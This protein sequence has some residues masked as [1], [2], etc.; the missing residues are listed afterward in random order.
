MKQYSWSPK[1]K[2]KIR[3]DFIAWIKSINNGFSSRIKYKPFEQYC[4][5]ADDWMKDTLFENDMR[6]HQFDIMKRE[7]D[8][9]DSNSYYYFARYVHIKDGDAP[10]GEWSPDNRTTFDVQKVFAFLNDTGLS[11]MFGKARQIG[12]TSEL[13]PIACKEAMCNEGYFVKFVCENDDKTEEIFSDKLKYS[14]YKLP[15][16]MKPSVSNDSAGLLQFATKVAKGKVEGMMSKVA[17]VGPTRTAIN[18]GSPNKTLVDE[19]GEIGILREMMDEARPTLYMYNSLTEEWEQKR[20]VIMWGTAGK[21][22]DATNA[23]EEIFR[24]LM[25]Q[26]MNDDLSAG[27]IPVFLDYTARQGL[28]EKQYENFK[29]AYLQSKGQAEKEKSLRA[30]KQHYPRDLDDMF[31]RDYATMLDMA[32]INSHIDRVRVDPKAQWGR[33]EPIF[34]KNN[35]LVAANWVP[36]S[37]DELFTAPICIVEHPQPGWKNRYY[38]GTDPIQGISGHSKMASAIFDAHKNSIPALMNWRIEDYKQC[39]LQSA[40]LGIYYDHEIKELIESNV[41]SEYISYLESIGLYNTMIASLQLPEYLRLRAADTAIGINKRSANTE[42][43]MNK[44]AELFISFADNI[45]IEEFFLQLKTFS[46][47]I[48]KTGFKWEPNSRYD[49]DDALDAACYAYIARLCYTYLQAMGHDEVQKRKVVSRIGY[50]ENW[51]LV[52]REEFKT[53]KKN[54]WRM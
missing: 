15:E 14:F 41:G 28:N 36:A 44:M 42:F 29:K 3:E 2:G 43:I 1:V 32:E 52:K 17:V 20:Q 9:I 33:F 5:Q 10:N 12:S 22:S 4:K 37:D 53:V 24:G 25:E 19:I 18:G 27:I 45:E 21:M 39:Y 35:R 51:N 48:T 26:F 30:F 49:F 47:K 23:Y 34:D 11:Y 31:T 54:K 8:R 7:R 46:K 6:D 16:W 50:D 13:L 38:K 40:C